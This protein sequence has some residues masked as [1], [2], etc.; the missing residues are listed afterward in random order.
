VRSY[1]APALG[2]LPVLLAVGLLLF[3][4]PGHDRSWAEIRPHDA[5]PWT[6][7]WR[8]LL[9]HWVHHGWAHL[10]MNGIALGAWFGIWPASPLV[11]LRAL[12]VLGVLT[13][14]GLYLVSDR[15]YVVGLSGLL[16][17]LFVASA[18]TG[19]R[20]P[21]T[22]TTGLVVLAAIALKLLLEQTLG[23]SAGTEALIGLPVATEAH[24]I[25]ALA[26]ALYAGA[27]LRSGPKE[28]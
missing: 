21:R 5:F 16:H 10:L 7:P 13:G 9:G 11:R 24:W 14:A 3:G 19:L 18:I 15:S 4:M 2:A 8:L 28:A 6:A 25:G 1:T 26:G 22:R 20:A 23:P 17:G 12:L 27:L